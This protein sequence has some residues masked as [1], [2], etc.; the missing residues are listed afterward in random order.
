MIRVRRI[1][2]EFAVS[3]EYSKI[4]EKFLKG[5]REI[6]IFV[7]IYSDLGGSKLRSENKYLTILD[8]RKI[9]LNV[10]GRN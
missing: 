1:E 9:Y 6:C 5:Q 7:M 10:K 4:C 2:I 8:N 3:N